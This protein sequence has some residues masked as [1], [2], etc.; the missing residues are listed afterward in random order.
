MRRGGRRGRT[1][2]MTGFERLKKRPQRAL[3]YRRNFFDGK[4]TYILYLWEMLEEHNLFQSS[5]QQLHED[6]G[7]VDGSTGVPPYAIGGKRKCSNDDS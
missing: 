1:I 5:T 2:A 6:V 7:S 3:D 4:S